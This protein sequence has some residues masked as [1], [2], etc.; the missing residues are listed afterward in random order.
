MLL[1]SSQALFLFVS[2]VTR[3]FKFVFFSSLNITQNLNSLRAKA[4]RALQVDEPSHY[5]QRRCVSH[6]SS[7]SLACGGHDFTCLQEPQQATE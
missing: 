5:V 3:Y 7:A 1:I 6:N 2:C 4:A